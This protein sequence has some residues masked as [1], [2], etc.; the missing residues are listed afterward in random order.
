[1]DLTD[2]FRSTL[3]SYPIIIFSDCHVGELMEAQNF[4]TVQWKIPK[5]VFLTCGVGHGET[6]LTAF[7]VALLDSGIGNLNLMKV[8]SVFPPGARIANLDE[9]TFEIPRG[10]LIPTVYTRSIHS[11]RGFI[12]ASAIGVGIPE[13]AA[14]N[15]MIFESS[16]I[17]PRDRAEKLVRDMISE[18]FDVRNV[19]L[20]EA[21]VASSET[22]VLGKV[23]CTVAAALLI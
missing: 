15:G 22:E 4:G 9:V 16:I 18:A 1:M 13:N 14:N 11:T 10:A 6:E 12:I 23:A 20:K 19:S 7:D 21:V 17:G 5:L 8:T 2:S 3:L